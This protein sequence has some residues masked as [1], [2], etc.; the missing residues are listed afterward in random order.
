MEKR[1]ALLC[2]IGLTLS[3][4]MTI[5]GCSSS[6]KAEDSANAAD[7]LPAVDAQTA[8]VPA[9]AAETPAVAAADAP[10]VPPV[11]P[12]ADEPK[13]ADPV[14]QAAPPAPAATGESSYTVQEGDT[15]M[16]I[17]FENYGDLYQWKK[18]LEDNKDK[19]T[20]ANTIPK[21]TVLKMQSAGP[22][23]IARNG[24][25]YLIKSGDTLGTISGDVYGT[26]SKWRK[27]WENNKQLI[28]DPNRIFA[29]FYLYYTPEDNGVTTKP[30]PMVK[31]EPAAAPV[32]E[33]SSE[34]VPAVAAPAVADPAATGK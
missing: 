25:K 29:G 16:K 5:T 32:R 2:V 21:G 6:K 22:A 26:Q 33:P 30:A 23:E 3:S 19:I 34:A 28:K 7:Q 4:A 11:A 8:A 20:S 15:L 9:V 1:I 10:P 13:V 31:T 18:I 14:A 24:E 12:V 17:A 27:L